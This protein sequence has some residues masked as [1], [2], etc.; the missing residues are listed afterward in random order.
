MKT[1]FVSGSFNVLHPGHLRLIKFAKSH[2]DKLVV[3]IF[4]DK[5]AGKAAH[6]SEKLRLDSLK[7]KSVPDFNKWFFN[8]VFGVT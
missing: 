2:G 1:V 3:G 8:K 6:V 5:I 4:S 7:N